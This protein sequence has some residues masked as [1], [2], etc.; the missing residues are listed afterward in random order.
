MLMLDDDIQFVPNL[1]K[2]DSQLIFSQESSP[3]KNVVTHLLT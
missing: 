1:I 2:Q 3:T